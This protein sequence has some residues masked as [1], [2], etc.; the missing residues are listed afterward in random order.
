LE[1]SCGGVATALEGNSGTEHRGSII[2]LGAISDL[3][4]MRMLRAE[5]ALPFETPSDILRW[6][7]AYLERT[8]DKPDLRMS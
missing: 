6:F 5:H 7:G 1:R 2:L 4:R 3:A 8:L